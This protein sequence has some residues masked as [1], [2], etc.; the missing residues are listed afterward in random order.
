MR[1]MNMR[2]HCRLDWRHELP[3]IA[4]SVKNMIR[5]KCGRWIWDFIAVLAEDINCHP[6]Q[7]GKVPLYWQFPPWA[8]YIYLE[9]MMLV[10]KK[11]IACIY[12]F[13]PEAKLVC[14]KNVKQKRPTKGEQLQIQN[15]KNFHLWKSSGFVVFLLLGAFLFSMFS[16]NFRC[17]VAFVKWYGLTSF[18]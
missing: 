14:D 2:F 5:Q 18:Q 8:P 3:L 7:S 12:T 9:K 15:L 17:Y 10:M 1:K 11:M 16:F 13:S 4:I 6:G